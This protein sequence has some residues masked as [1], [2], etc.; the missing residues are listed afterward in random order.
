MKTRPLAPVE[1]ERHIARFT[2]LQPQK[3]EYEKR[4]IPIE[5]FEMLADKPQRHPAFHRTDTLDFALVQRATNHA[6]SNHGDK[7]AR[8]YAVMVGAL[9]LEKEL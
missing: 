8:V 7:V 2:Q 9:P 6:W 5:A 4:G 3:A 1:M